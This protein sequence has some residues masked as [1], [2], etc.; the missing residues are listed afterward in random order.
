MK[1]IDLSWFLARWN[2]SSA[3]GSA[4]SHFRS[5]PT[6]ESAHVIAEDLGGGRDIR[7]RHQRLHGDESLRAIHKQLQV[8]GLEPAIEVHH[9]LSSSPSSSPTVYSRLYM[10]LPGP[11][12]LNM[13]PPP[14]SVCRRLYATMSACERERETTLGRPALAVEAETHHRH[15]HRR[16]R[17]VTE[18]AAQGTRGSG[19]GSG[20]GRGEGEGTRDEVDEAVVLDADADDAEVAR[21]E[22]LLPEAVKDGV[23]AR[24]QG[25]PG[26]TARGCACA[27]GG[28]KEWSRRTWLRGCTTVE[29]RRDMYIHRQKGVVALHHVVFVFVV[30]DVL[31]VMGGIGTHVALLDLL[32]QQPRVENGVCKHVHAFL[33]V[34]SQNVRN[35][36]DAV[37][38]TPS[39]QVGA[40]VFQISDQ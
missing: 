1:T 32:V 4:T 6:H 18:A 34:A 14:S 40:D 31:G 29:G 27:A 9:V 26:D 7:Q 22:M 5:S 24:S 35:V 13:L 38:T 8:A 28:R 25:R 37:T 2:S 11:P 36:D 10:P 17:A 33:D 23:V 15:V 3:A 12:A 16:L 39:D 19:R 20:R 21:R 30:E